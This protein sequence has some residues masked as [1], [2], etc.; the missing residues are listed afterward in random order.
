MRGRLESGRVWMIGVRCASKRLS[1]TVCNTSCAPRPTRGSTWPG[2]E[3]IESQSAKATE[4]G[5]R[6]DIM[7]ASKST[8]ASLKPRSTRTAVRSRFSRI[9]LQFK[10]RW[11]GTADKGLT[12]RLSFRRAG[13]FRKRLQCLRVASAT[14]IATQVVG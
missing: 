13:F 5:S 8:T 1:K 9:R 14:C 7:P 2:R 10:S 11:C 3:F 6:A 12:P 4:A